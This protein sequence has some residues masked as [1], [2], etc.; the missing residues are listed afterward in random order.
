MID[1]FTTVEEASKALGVS[2]ETIYR[3]FKQG[4]IDGVR[5]GQKIIKIRKSE[6]ERLLGGGNGE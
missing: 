6:I 2:R 4:D 5:V 1:E 3:W